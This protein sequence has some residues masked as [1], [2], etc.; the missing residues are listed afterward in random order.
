MTEAELNQRLSSYGFRLDELA[1]R[2]RMPEQLILSHL[3]DTPS[4][5]VELESQR[6]W[7]DRARRFDLAFHRLRATGQIEF[8]N[9][10]WRV[11]RSPLA[12]RATDPRP[13]KAVEQKQRSLF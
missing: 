3:A 5:A 1:D 12:E 10:L 8:A 9:A 7:K 2:D 11:V 13:V 4:T 6:W